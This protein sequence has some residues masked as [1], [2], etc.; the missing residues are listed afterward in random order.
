MTLWPPLNPEVG[1]KFS[2]HVKVL[3]GLWEWFSEIQQLVS[4]VNVVVMGLQM[5]TSKCFLVHL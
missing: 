4:H 5:L 3:A 2:L 1:P